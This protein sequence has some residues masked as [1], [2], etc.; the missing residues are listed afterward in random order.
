[1]KDVYGSPEN[2]NL[3][4]L[5]ELDEENLSYEFNMLIV[6]IENKEENPKLY[7]AQ[8]SGCSCPLPFE[9]YQSINDLNLI[10]KDNFQEFENSVNNF[11]ISLSEKMDVLLKVKELLT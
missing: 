1:M 3:K 9:S 5:A 4:I 10:T 8:D 6:W 11:P 2:Y 7:W